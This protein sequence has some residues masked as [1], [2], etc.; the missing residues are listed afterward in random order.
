MKENNKLS[1]V[2][3]EKERLV[4]VELIKSCPIKQTDHNLKIASHRKYDFISFEDYKQKLINGERIQN[5]IPKTS[6]HIVSFYNYL[7][8]NHQNMISKELFESEYNQTLNS[9]DDIAKKYKI[10]REY[11]SHLRNFYGIKR[12]GATFIRRLT[13]EQPLSQEAKDVIVGSMLG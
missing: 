3:S 12:K 4:L 6:K 10:Q 1:K 2:L 8:K 9:L 7:L 5:I 13:N 11:I